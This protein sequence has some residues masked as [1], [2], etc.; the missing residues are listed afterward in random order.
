[1]K[2]LLTLILL[3]CSNGV[4]GQTTSNLKIGSGL[5]LES[6]TMSTINDVGF[7]QWAPNSLIGSTNTVVK[8]K[9]DTTVLNKGDASHSHEWAYKKKVISNISCAVYH[10]ETGC[11][12][13]WPNDFRTG[14]TI[15][16]NAKKRNWRRTKL[17]M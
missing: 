17:G 13:D 15:R 2:K 8:S 7:V 3:L 4:I 16:Y 1:M 9:S 12:N 6:G 14:N 11:P 5:T 10:G